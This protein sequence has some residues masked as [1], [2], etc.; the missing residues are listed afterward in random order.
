[1]FYILFYQVIFL[2]SLIN[3]F[4]TY[5]VVRNNTKVSVKNLSHLVMITQCKLILGVT[6]KTDG[7]RSV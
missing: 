4:S 7:E 3:A 6:E 5:T 1:M 2:D